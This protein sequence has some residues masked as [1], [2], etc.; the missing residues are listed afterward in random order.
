MEWKNIYKILLLLFVFSLVETN[1]FAAST[2]GIK[3]TIID[4]QTEDVLPFTNVIL[5]GTSMGAAAD[6][7]GNYSIKNITPGTY[8]VRAKYIGYKQEEVTVEVKEGKTIICDFALSPESV[9]GDT[10]IVTAQAEGQMAAINEQ[11]TSIPIKNVVSAAKIQELPDANAAESVG[12]LPGV[13]IIRTGGEGARV[14]V[15]GLSPQ[16]NRVTIDGVE[17]PSNFTSNDP[18]DHKTEWFI[19]S[20]DQLS[21]SGDRSTDL[22]MISSNMLG[23]IEVIKAIT[24]DMDATAIGGVINFSMRKAYKNKLNKPRF[25]VLSQGSYK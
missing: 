11:L 1:L 18:N 25:E 24:P 17:L 19:G 2:G 8:T 9:L 7:D 22:S 10:L 15:R 23:G 20:K 4:A 12:R 16:Y 21:L 6:F 3:G 14:V 13:S 5:M